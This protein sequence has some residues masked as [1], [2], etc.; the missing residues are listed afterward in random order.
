MNVIGNAIAFQVVWMSSVG[1]AARGWW[2]AGPL[3]LLAFMLWQLPRSDCRR[4]DMRLMAVAAVVGFLVDSLWVQAQWLQFTAPTP[5]AHMA[6]I[7]IVTMWMGFALTL[8]HSLRLFKQRLL[9][10]AAFGLVGGPLA[11]WIAANTWSAVSLPAEHALALVSIG[12]AWALLT[13]ALLSLSNRWAPD[14][15]RAHG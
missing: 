7:W 12:I 6:P 11:Y 2:W 10:S 4:A 9:W 14:A 15:T 3:A 5:S 1:G 13:P 8:N